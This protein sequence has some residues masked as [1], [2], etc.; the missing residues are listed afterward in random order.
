MTGRI[1]TSSAGLL[2]VVGHPKNGG[3]NEDVCC[4]S[5]TKG[6]ELSAAWKI[7]QVKYPGPPLPPSL[8]PWLV[9]PPSQGLA[10]QGFAYPWVFPWCRTPM[11]SLIWA[12][13]SRLVPA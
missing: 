1:G 8:R 12:G 9:S 4:D 5:G 7:G 3:I 11:I 10:F 6:V 2:V 13:Y